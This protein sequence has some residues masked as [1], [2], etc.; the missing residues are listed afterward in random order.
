MRNYSRLHSVRPNFLVAQFSNTAGLSLPAWLMCPSPEWTGVEVWRRGGAATELVNS[1][2]TSQLTPSVTNEEPVRRPQ[3]A[4]LAPALFACIIARRSYANLRHSYCLFVVG[5]RAITEYKFLSRD[6][7]SVPAVAAPPPVKEVTAVD[8]DPGGSLT[9]SGRGLVRGTPAICLKEALKNCERRRRNITYKTIA[10]LSTAAGPR[11]DA[12]LKIITR[13]CAVSLKRRGLPSCL[14]VHPDCV[15]RVD[16]EQPPLLGSSSANII[17][18]LGPPGLCGRVDL[19]QALLLPSSSA[20]IIVSLGPPGLRRCSGLPRP[21]ISC[22]SVHPDCVARGDLE[23][24]PLFRSSSANIIVS[25]GP[26]GLRRCCSGLPRPTLSCLS[27][28]QDCVARVDL[29][30]PLLFRSSSANII[31][32]LGPSGLCGRVDLEQPLL[33]RFSSAGIIVPLGPPG[34]CG[35]C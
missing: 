9:A 1:R 15:A 6:L 21:K 31:V 5:R 7:D 13:R 16:L 24:P 17:V 12:L 27:V 32:P 29:E 3:G 23:Q 18:P 26:P 8:L 35:P 10:S 4:A 34:L 33:F 11:P 25:L 2:I 20:N 19:E 30:Q 14:S 28:H 22:L